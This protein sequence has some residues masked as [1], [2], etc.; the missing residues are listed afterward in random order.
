MVGSSS[1]TRGTWWTFTVLGLN[2]ITSNRCQPIQGIEFGLQGQSRATCHA[3]PHAEVVSPDSLEFPTNTK[4]AQKYIKLKIVRSR[5]FIIPAP[6]PKK[7]ERK[8]V[9]IT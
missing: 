4:M 5:A 1:I 6:E 8:V 3:Q 9:K 2:Q 7:N